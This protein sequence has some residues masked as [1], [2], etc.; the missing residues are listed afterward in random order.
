MRWKEH[1]LYMGEDRN[2]YR[3]LVGKPEQKKQF[4]SPALRRGIIL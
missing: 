4:G 3:I 2:E 1:V